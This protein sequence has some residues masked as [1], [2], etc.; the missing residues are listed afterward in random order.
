M[1]KVGGGGSGS[2]VKRTVASIVLAVVWSP[3]PNHAHPPPRRDSKQV[4]RSAHTRRRTHVCN[5][6]CKCRRKE[7]GGSHAPMIDLAVRKVSGW[8]Q[9]GVRMSG[10]SAPWSAGEPR[11]ACAAQERHTGQPN[12][13]YDCTRCVKSMGR[14]GRVRGLGK[15]GGA[16]LRGAAAVTTPFILTT[17]SRQAGPQKIPPSGAEQSPCSSVLPKKQAKSS[18]RWGVATAGHTYVARGRVW[19]KKVL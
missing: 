4:Q 16:S 9:D 10:W 2:E 8:C 3:N 19:V 6:T 14:A 17:S 13:A 7:T 18:V 15:G 5:T 1:G 11:P 12:A